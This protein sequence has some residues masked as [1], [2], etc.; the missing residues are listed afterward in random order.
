MH[1]T[2]FI[3]TFLAAIASIYA[4]TNDFRRPQWLMVN[5]SR[6]GITESHLRTLGALK[7][8]GGLG[9]IV[10][11]LIPNIGIAAATGLV[12]YFLGAV[13]VSIRAHWLA[14]LPYPLV[15]LTLSASALTL[16]ILTR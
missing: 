12:L 8:A 3:V 9:L 16:R 10:G 13:F 6:L 5:M 2:Y 7:L 15:W 1:T 14:H 4:A 11:T